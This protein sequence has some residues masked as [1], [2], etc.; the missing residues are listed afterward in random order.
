MPHE[1]AQVERQIFL[2]KFVNRCRIVSVLLGTQAEKGP[3]RCDVVKPSP[4]W[5]HWL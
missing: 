2:T 3:C 1:A 4:P 5:R